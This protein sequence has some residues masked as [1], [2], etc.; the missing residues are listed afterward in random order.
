MEDAVCQEI[1]RD[2]DSQSQDL[3]GRYQ[4]RSPKEAWQGWSRY[5]DLRNEQAAP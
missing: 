5:L 4:A 2:W 3:V 1:H